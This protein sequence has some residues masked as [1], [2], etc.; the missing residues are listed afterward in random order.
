MKNDFFKMDLHIHT[1]ASKC[2]KDEKSEKSYWN[3]LEN[4]VQKEIKIIAITDH[5]TLAGYEYFMKL[6]EDTLNE[7]SIIKK[8]NIPEAERIEIEH[9]KELFDQLY[10]VLGVEITINPGIHIIVLAKEE[11]KDDL[12]KLLDDMGY[13]DDKRGTDG[14]FIPNTDI[15]TFLEKQSLDG[16]I[17]IAP[18]VDSDKGIWNSLDGLYRANVFKSDHLHAIS[19][20]SISQLKKIQTNIKS[21]PDYSR[22]KPIAFINAS[23][24]HRCDTIGSKYS[25]CSMQKFSFDELK[26]AFDSPE[27]LINDIGKSD[28][29]SLVDRCTESYKSVYIDNISELT[30]A[31]CA[32]LNNRS[33]CILLGISDDN[34]FVGIDAKE[35]ELKAQFERA[36]ENISLCNYKANK[37]QA[38]LN[39]Q[40]LGNGKSVALI[41]IRDSSFCLWACDKNNVYILDTEAKIKAATAKEIELIVKE[42]VISE[43]ELFNRRNNNNIKHAIRKLNQASN[44]ISK[45]VLF[46]KIKT[47]G[48]PL[49]HYFDII[50]IQEKTNSIEN[51]IKINNG[52]GAPKGNVYYTIPTS[53]RLPDAYLRFTCPVYES[54]DNEYLEKRL[55]FSKSAIILTDG[56]SCHLIDEPGEFYFD[57]CSSAILLVPKDRF[58]DNNSLYN[59]FAWLKSDVFL[60]FWLQKHGNAFIFKR[61]M[62]DDLVIPSDISANKNVEIEN[63]VK[64]IISKEQEFLVQFNAV[65]ISDTPQIERMCDIHNQ[66]ISEVAFTIEKDI[67]CKLQLSEEDVEFVLNDLT[68]E[69]IYIHPRNNVIS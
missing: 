68:S 58:Y 66:S 3:I 16:K 43:I 6:R 40:E 14:D 15:K 13:T 41:L 47:K 32:V 54:K 52:N 11:E 25:F 8:Y 46:D 22:K 26:R 35:E 29:Y 12:D 4:A 18:H 37:I 42:N 24:S 59:V 50:E 48:S 57:S 27:S 51:I 31:L 44:P 67:N 36:L 19:C 5:N 61:Q 64:E 55:K 39:V 53:P 21:Q 63:S 23:D 9:K 45:F 1:P 49:S 34:S 28:F 30:K 10:I 65:N 17:V 33:G 2:Y 56:G 69:K 38:N 60:W 7:Y 62:W 20:N